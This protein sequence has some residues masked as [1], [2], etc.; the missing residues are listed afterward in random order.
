M[1]AYTTL[2]HST[3][4]HAAKSAEKS[5]S[6]KKSTS[7]EKP[8]AKAA[9]TRADVNKLLSKAR[10]AMAAGKLTKANDLVTQ[11]EGAKLN[12]PVLNFGDSPSKARRDLKKLM[13]KQG[14]IT[15]PR[16]ADKKAA[17]KQDPFQKK[18]NPVASAKQ[19]DSKSQQ[20]AS[21]PNLI[22]P[23]PPQVSP[24]Q[25]SRSH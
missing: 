17:T 15:G 12:Y 7:A 14:S 5:A 6:A 13:G 21:V 8:A 25:P 24:V 16:Y 19:A 3:L 11:A 9:L 23:K 4:I 2:N 1:L 20:Q 10:E 22:A 18:S